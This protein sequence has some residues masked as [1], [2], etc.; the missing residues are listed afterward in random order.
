MKP[1]PRLLTLAV[2]VMV[3]V[4]SPGCERPQDTLK[5]LQAE[6]SAY[7]SNPSDEAAA[8]IEANFTRLDE[9]IAKLRRNGEAAEADTLAQQ[10]AALQ[11]QYAAARMTASLLKAKEAAVG[12]GEAFRKAGEAFGEALKGQPENND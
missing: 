5:A 6:V 3:L 12:V 10:K 1:F 7:A 9:Q 2:A 8:K 4:F 11:T